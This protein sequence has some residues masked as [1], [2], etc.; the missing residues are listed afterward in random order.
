MPG[1]DFSCFKTLLNMAVLKA[2]LAV[3]YAFGFQ[4]V[5]HSLYCL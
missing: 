1:L 5:H 4:V 3:F 2:V